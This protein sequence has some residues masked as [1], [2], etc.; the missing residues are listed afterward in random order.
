MTWRN[1]KKLFKGK[2]GKEIFPDEIFLDSSNLPQFDVHQF[3]GR[4]EQPIPRSALFILSLLFIV[5]AGALVTKVWSLQINKGGEYAE[6]SERNRLRHTTIFSER[7]VVYDRNNKL[8]AWNVTNE[9]NPDFALRDYIDAP[10]FAHILGYVKYPRKDSSGLYYSEQYEPQDGVEKFYNEILQGRNGIKI[11]E[12][13]AL[14]K[15]VSENV[16]DPPLA[17]KGLTLSIDADLQEQMYRAI[18]RTADEVGFT[19]GAGGLIDLQ[20][21]EILA[22]TNYPEYDPDILSSGKDVAAIRAMFNNPHNPFLDRFVEGLYTPGSVVKPFLALGVLKEGLIDPATK[23]ISTGSISIPNPYDPTK[24]SVF[25]DWRAHGSINMREAIAVS[26]NVYFYVVGGGYKDQPGLGISKIEQY[27]KV[28]G[29]GERVEGS[30]YLAGKKG[31]IPNPEWKKENFKGEEWRIGDTYNTSIGQYGMQVTPIQML[32][33]VSALATNGKIIKPTIIKGENNENTFGAITTFTDQQYRVIK[34]GMR[35]GA[36]EGTARALNFPGAEI[37]AK[38]GTAEI[39]TANKT[40]VNSWVIGYFPYNEPKYAFVFLME[41]GPRSNT[42]GAS[43]I[44]KNFFEWL[45]LNQP[46][47]FQ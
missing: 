1:V 13:N 47:Y 8:L 19:G 28:F 29:F 7:G 26:S 27:M 42:I 6:K 34:E 33:G 25:T 2:R 35:L 4:I 12:T 17:G 31:T 24:T 21:G 9:N 16:I 18:R 46:Q 43:Y 23:I 44:A 20:T 45:L 41:R 36:T 40:H 22:M 3:E 39:G 38:T 14:S 30:S 32:V 11:I 10:G 5:I 15:V 37:A